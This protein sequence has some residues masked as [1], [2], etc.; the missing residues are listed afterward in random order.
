MR[1]IVWGFIIGLFV[2]QSCNTGSPGGSSAV[3]TA[4]AGSPGG[5]VLSGVQG[6]G[7]ITPT[8]TIT[9]TGTITP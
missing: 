5:V 2:L 1:W 6:S 3:G 7:T 9:P 8:M 4:G